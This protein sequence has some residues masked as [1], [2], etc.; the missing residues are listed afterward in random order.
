MHKR[1][2]WASLLA[3][4]LFLDGCGSSSVPGRN[5]INGDWTATLTNSDGSLAYQFSATFTQGSGSELSITNLT[6]TTSSSCPVLASLNSAGG[7]FTP[8]TETLA[9]S[10]I[11]MN[12][13][14]PMLSLQGKLSSG[15]I[16]GQW[17]LNGLVP[18]CSGSGTFMMQP[19]LPLP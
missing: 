9:M 18:P 3:V 14:G 6:Y 17:T 16:S 4:A 2:A 12:V 19:I 11:F 1:I 7:S 10:E 13:G 5:N 8:S 15:T